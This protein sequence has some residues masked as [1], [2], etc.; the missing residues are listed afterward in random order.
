ML[1][2]SGPEIE[3]ADLL[4]QLSEIENQEWDLKLRDARFPPVDK[5]A[6]IASRF[7]KAVEERESLHKLTSRSEGFFE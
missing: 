1:S 6:D 5:P 2:Q 3:E 7:E 4:K